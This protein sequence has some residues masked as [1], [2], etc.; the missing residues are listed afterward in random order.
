MI[1][2]QI[3]D[4]NVTKELSFYQSACIRC[5]HNQGPA[6]ING[7][8][9]CFSCRAF[10]VGIPEPIATGENPHTEPYPGDH[11]IRFEPK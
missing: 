11:G 5:V 6:D 1:K 3:L 2:K 7:T 8:H 10:P 4:D 9:F